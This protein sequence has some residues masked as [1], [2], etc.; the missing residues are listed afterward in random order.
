[1]W[2]F[3]TLM[4]YQLILGLLFLLEI[5]KYIFGKSYVVVVCK[6][7]FSYL[8]EVMKLNYKYMLVSPQK[9][10]HVLCPSPLL[11]SVSQM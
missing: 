3:K 7:S 6:N 8:G 2:G 4:K 5:S 1:M 9:A 10:K 11:F